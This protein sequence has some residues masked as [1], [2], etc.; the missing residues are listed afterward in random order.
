[1]TQAELAASSGISRTVIANLEAGN[2]QSV[3]LQTVEALARALSTDLNQLTGFDA[4]EEDT[5]SE[6]TPAAV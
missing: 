2:R 6:L 5:E 3:M 1:M 4:L